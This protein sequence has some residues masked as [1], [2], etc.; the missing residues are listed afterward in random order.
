M[1]DR[2]LFD[3]ARH[4]VCF[5]LSTKD[6][7]A[8]AL[9]AVSA[10]GFVDGF[11][12]LWFDGSTT[13]DARELP[14]RLAP[15]L[16]CLREIHADVR[17]GPDF[18]ILSAL[19]RMLELGYAYVGLLESDISHAPGWFTAMMAA[20]DAGAADGL[21]VGAVTTRAYARR[22]LYR[23]PRYAVTMVSGA[24]VIL[25]T[26]EAAELVVRHYR[27]TSSTEINNWLLF[28][29][30]KDR[31][32]LG[33][34]AD[35]P[36]LPDTRT[37]SDLYYET[38]LQKHGLCVLATVPA[39]ARDLEREAETLAFLGPYCTA[40]APPD[41]RDEQSF[42]VFAK[43]CAEFRE[44]AS[45]GEQTVVP[46]LYFAS[47]KFWNVFLHQVLFTRTSPA[48]ICGRWKLVWDKFNGPFAFEALEPGCQISFPLYGRLNGIMCSRSANCGIVDVL[49]GD[50][51]CGSFDTYAPQES[52]E[53][54]FMP[55]DLAPMGAEPVTFRVAE[56]PNPASG[57]TMFRISSLCLDEIPP[58]LPGRAAFDA[59]ALVGRF[60]EQAR[61]G[62][63]T[64]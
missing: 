59:A 5:S 37:S 15:S 27:T 41:E 43:R 36:A 45:R 52:T 57:G 50:R 17:G 42:S 12:L 14:H 47:M 44:R 35:Q 58:W 40:D 33:E 9:E 11:D 53:Q 49:S 4:S 46:Y 18:A 30:G 38:A 61:A 10:L 63:V 56:R 31:A 20:F 28:V 54:F 39:Y 32:K 60:E 16:A 34:G 25:F 64:F 19:V 1:L 3:A 22:I 29:S 26:R 23:R 51:R 55:L 48:R 24:G 21:A 7:T 13:G 2:V 8:H 62:F 6:R